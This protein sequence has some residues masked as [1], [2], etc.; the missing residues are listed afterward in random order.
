LTTVR[1]AGTKRTTEAEL[2]RSAS[3]LLSFARPLL[4]PA[5]D[6]HTFAAFS[7]NVRFDRAKAREG[8]HRSA[9]RTPRRRPILEPQLLGNISGVK[10]LPCDGTATRT[11]SP[12]TLELDIPNSPPLQRSHPE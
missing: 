8:V 5:L 1:S 11:C 9:V 7:T 3:D 4:N 10:L 6:A 12:S 2:E